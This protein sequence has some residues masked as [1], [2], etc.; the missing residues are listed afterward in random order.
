MSEKSVKGLGKVDKERI[1]AF[2]EQPLPLKKDGTPKWDKVPIKKLTNMML[3]KDAD[4]TPLLMYNDGKQRFG[5]TI[6]DWNQYAYIKQN[7]LA[8]FVN[9]IDYLDALAKHIFGNNGNS[10]RVN[11]I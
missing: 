3:V 11:A 5:L 6:K 9:N 8:N 7:I 2:L 1:N 10:T 4:G